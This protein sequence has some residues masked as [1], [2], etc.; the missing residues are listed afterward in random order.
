MASNKNFNHIGLKLRDFMK[1]C[2]GTKNYAYIIDIRTSK[3]LWKIWADKK[4]M[5]M[6]FYIRNKLEICIFSY[7]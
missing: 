7:G 3:E 1:F 2:C 6:Y 4:I 5:H